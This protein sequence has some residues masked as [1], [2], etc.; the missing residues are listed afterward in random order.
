M[1]QSPDDEARGGARRSIWS[2]PRSRWLLG[3][4]MGGLVMLVLGV[5]FA[6]GFTVVLHATSSP[7]F[8]ANACHSM[9]DFVAPEVA[10]SVHGKNGPGVAA[11]CPDCHVP[12]PFL[13][14]MIRK[15]Q[16]LREVWGEA[17]GVLDTR[18]KFEAHRLAMAESVWAAMKSTGSRECRTCHNFEKMDFKAQDSFAAR[19]HQAAMKKGETCIDCHTGVAHSLPAAKEEGGA[20]A[21]QRPSQ[22]F[23]RE[24]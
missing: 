13:A 20:T 15:I 21:P 10:S 8:C 23:A 19:R 17:T 5:V 12:Q 22:T 7:Q 1:Q 3:I 4:P 24:Q 11:T 16:A 18:D 14:M 9:R 2:K 6:S